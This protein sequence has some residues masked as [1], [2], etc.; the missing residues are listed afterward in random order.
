M[1]TLPPCIAAPPRPVHVAAL[2][3]V[4]AHVEHARQALDKA[5][6]NFRPLT[7]AP[8]VY[9]SPLYAKA[10]TYGARLDRRRPGLH[11]R[12]AELLAAVGELN[13][14]DPW[15]V[16]VLQALAGDHAA[17]AMLEWMAADHPLTGDVAAFL[18]AV[19]ADL[20]ARPET[21]TVA[22]LTDSRAVEPWCSDTRHRA[23][24]RPSHLARLVGSVERCAPP[25]PPVR[26][27][28]QARIKCTPRRIAAPTH[29]HNL[30]ARDGP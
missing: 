27:H 26:G 19:A 5:A 8:A 21:L 3:R 12:H 14:L 11:R 18:H 20:E 9:M 30:S 22:L 28:G 6:A 25:A 10:R 15:A 1:P 13:V 7:S 2:G 17:A 4:M 24:P 16:T 29:P 23:R